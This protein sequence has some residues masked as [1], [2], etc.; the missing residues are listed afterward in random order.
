MQTFNIKKLILS[1]SLYA[2]FNVYIAWI[3]ITPFFRANNINPLQ[4]ST[5]HTIQTASWFVFLYISGI[6]F[7]IFGAKT[8]FLVGRFASLFATTLLLKPSFTSFVFTMALFGISR[9][10]IYGKYTS[11]V[12]NTLSIAGKLNIYPRVASAYYFVWDIAISLTSYVAS[13]ILKNNDYQLLIKIGIILQILAIAS[14]FILI[15]SNNSSDFKQFQSSS[16]KEIFT[17]IIA[18]M[19]KSSI[20]TYMLLF[21]GLLTFITYP[22]FIIIG[23]MVLVDNGWTGAEVAKYTTVMT[24]MMAIGTAIPII[25]F[26]NG[27]S[28][29]KCVQISFIQMLLALLAMLIY[30]VWFFIIVG[31][32]TCMTYSLFQVS[33]ERRFEEYSNKKVRGSA[34][35]FSLS[36]GTL[37]QMFNVMLLGMIAKNF[38]YHIGMLVILIPICLLAFFFTKK[39][40]IK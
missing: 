11:F 39:I 15:P 13:L 23:D 20:F 19:K 6:A 32:F 31:C 38:S 14:V 8:I 9:G 5:L 37:L 12:Y 10:I 30:N 2:F 33:I 36:I 28:V 26:P 21:Y 18:C 17:S 1:N 16:V 22:L 25:I 29:K 34:T 4:I 35:S 40:N 3:V 24:T 7:D 27:I